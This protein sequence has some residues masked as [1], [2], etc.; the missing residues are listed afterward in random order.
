[1]ENKARLKFIANL[2]FNVLPDLANGVNVFV[3]ITDIICIIDRA[4]DND[5]VEIRRWA[6]KQRIQT[7]MINYSIP[8]I[9]RTH[10][11]ITDFAYNTCTEVADDYFSGCSNAPDMIVDGYPILVYCPYYN[12]SQKRVEESIFMR[13]RDLQ[14]LLLSYNK[15]PSYAIQDCILNALNNNHLGRFLISSESV[16]LNPMEP[17][18]NDI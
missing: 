13:P 1:M 16:H 12:G 17:R 7:N 2:F 11:R 4:E 9:L 3:C 10:V 5:G 15:Q 14:R 8:F 6:A 18:T